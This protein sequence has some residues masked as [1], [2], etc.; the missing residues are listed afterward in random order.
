V[1]EEKPENEEP[2]VELT[3]DKE[4]NDDNTDTDMDFSEFVPTTTK[5]R[6]SSFDMRPKVPP[7][8]PVHPKAAADQATSPVLSTPGGSSL[9]NISPI[10]P[11]SSEANSPDPP[12][13]MDRNID[14]I[15]SDPT[16]EEAAAD[17]T[18]TLLPE[19]SI[20]EELEP[21][22]HPELV[23]ALSNENYGNELFRQKVSRRKELV[24]EVLN[25]ERL[26]KSKDQDDIQ[27]LRMGWRWPVGDASKDDYEF[28]DHIENIKDELPPPT[29]RLRGFAPGKPPTTAEEFFD[30]VFDET[31]WDDLR[32]GTNEYAAAKRNSLG[33]KS[34]FQ[35]WEDCTNSEVKL[36]FALL[37]AMGTVKKRDIPSYWNKTDAATRTPFFGT[38]MPRN[39][40]QNIYWNLHVAHD[41]A[42]DDHPLK[43]MKPMLDKCNARFRHAYAPGR[44]LSYDECSCAFRG[45]VHFLSYNPKKPHKYHI[46]VYACCESS[47]YTLG[48]DPYFGAKQREQYSH[49]VTETKGDV[50]TNPDRNADWPLSTEGP[51]AGT[52]KGNNKRGAVA[53]GVSASNRGRCN[54]KQGAVAQKL[55]LS[56]RGRGNNKRGAVATR[57]SVSN[58]GRGN[59][60]R[61]AV[62]I[63]ASVSKRGRGNNKRGAVGTRATVSNRGTS[64]T[65]GKEEID[66]SEEEDHE[67]TFLESD[68]EEDEEETFPEENDQRRRRDTLSKQRKKIVARSKI[69]LAK[70]AKKTAEANERGAYDRQ[71]LGHLDDMNLL[72]KGHF[73][74]MDNLYTS[75]T[76]LAALL[77]RKTFACGTVRNNKVGFPKALSQLTSKKAKERGLEMPERGDM[78][79]RRRNI[80]GTD[81]SLL[82]I[83]FTDKKQ[84]MLLS[85]IHT[86]KTV[87]VK[88]SRRKEEWN[89]AQRKKLENFNMKMNIKETILAIPANRRTATEKRELAL[90]KRAVKPKLPITDVKPFAVYDYNFD[91]GGPDLLGQMIDSYDFL[92]PTLSWPKKLMLWTFSCVIV[93]AYILNSKFGVEKDMSHFEF[94]S[95]IITHLLSKAAFAGS[96]A[97]DATDMHV[98]QQRL[99]S[100]R[101]FPQT[102]SK[103]HGRTRQAQCVACNF[104]KNDL[105]S[106]LTPEQAPVG[107]KLKRI[108][109]SFQ[110]KACQVP[111]CLEPCFE[112]YHTFVDF[113][114]ECLELRMKNQ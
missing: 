13:N 86:A 75:P 92:R 81:G 107:E 4:C 26:P 33:P 52:S 96:G 14:A 16:H 45:R 43:K 71:V 95:R 31:L 40:F 36:V 49:V 82:A 20:E 98:P 80:P 17:Q 38:V 46:L 104:N 41:A 3:L 19:S 7:L 30:H 68:A 79:A 18:T 78:K 9:A 15:A 29:G 93:N 91:M 102:L 74:F 112:I 73:I 39:R 2:V 109:T 64:K 35:N 21:S 57:A 34:R 10:L 101:H 44:R 84:V 24:L 50:T 61:G 105:E 114:Q 77:K 63:R 100:G 94:R 58:R 54:N 42:H 47:G 28:P 70:A 90:L 56:N 72:D 25:M 85:S 65:Q 69:T 11:V 110:C 60:K 106:L 103:L 83:H 108:R 12:Q 37:I 89:A 5:K 32:I 59:N 62:A 6:S 51:T 99:S 27:D 76:L 88:L 22:G 55:S 8:T 1:R 48:L 87:K 66:E 23:A 67:A 53:T 113:R 97:L 111:L